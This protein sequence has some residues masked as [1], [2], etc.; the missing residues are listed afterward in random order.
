MNRRDLQQ[1]AD[2]RAREAGVLLTN[3]LYSGAYYLCGYAVECALKACIAK[4]VRCHDFPDRKLAYDSYTHDLERLAVVA[5]LKDELELKK[6][7][8]Q[9]F[10][11]NWMVV[12]QWSEET[13]YERTYRER[14]VNLYKAIT[15]QQDGVLA[16][17]QQYW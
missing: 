16:W 3:R 17:L 5:G 6:D 10:E 9:G 4:Q 12:I 13:R 1:L 8:N 14:A 11:R 7:S 2:I 15:D